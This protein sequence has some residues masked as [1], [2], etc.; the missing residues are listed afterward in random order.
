[1]LNPLAQLVCRVSLI[2]QNVGTEVRNLL[3]VTIFFHFVLLDSVCKK[4]SQVPLPNAEGF[5][6]IVGS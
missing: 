3:Q 6:N 4:T 5:L 2:V 1:M